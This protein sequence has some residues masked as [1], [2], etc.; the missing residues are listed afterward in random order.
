MLI[1]DFEQRFQEVRQLIFIDEND[2]LREKCSDTDKLYAALRLGDSLLLQPTTEGN[3]KY[4]TYRK[5]SYLNKLVG[6]FA[7]SLYYIKEAL[8]YFE[9]E[10]GEEYILTLIHYGEIIK[11]TK[12]YEKAIDVFEKTLTYCNEHNLQ[13]YEDSIW[14]FKGK[15]YLEQGDVM[16]AERCFYR[17][18]TIRKK[19]NDKVMLVPSEKA[20]R[21]IGKIKR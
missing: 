7:T 6:C 21:Y 19:R 9:P 17:A 11:H 1:N 3:L 18:Y 16:N 15:C 20:L 10:G 14:Q 4:R 2:F 8:D 5:I 13:Q 12:A